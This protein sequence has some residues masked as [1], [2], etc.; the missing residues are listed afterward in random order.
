MPPIPASLHPRTFTFLLLPQVWSSRN[1]ALRR[2]R[3]DMMR[4]GIFGVIGLVVCAALF[5]G[6][7]WLTA[8]LTAYDE[9]GDYLLRLALSWLFMTFLAFLAFSGVVASLSTFF[10][11]DDL[12]LLLAAPVSKG[13]LFL[14][15]F[16]RTV[17]QAS[18]MVVIF[19]API[20]LGVGAARC[21]PASF[22]LTAALTVAPFAVIP[23]AVGSAATLVLVN[24]FPARRARDLLML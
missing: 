5:R 1:R 19:M 11:A 15:R 22:Y 20:L 13:R 24:V 18:W 9:F 4:A 21:A 3:G 2:E 16:S 14:A 6:A 8:Q 12:R 10:L 17:G 23:V 7:Y